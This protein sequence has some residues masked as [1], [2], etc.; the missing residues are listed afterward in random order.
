LG[1]Q[2]AEEAGVVRRDYHCAR[3]VTTYDDY[4]DSCYD[5]YDY[6]SYDYDYF[7]SDY[8]DYDSSDYDYYWWF[9]SFVFCDS[10]GSV[11]FGLCGVCSCDE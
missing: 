8:D 1:C 3:W 11:G 7:W 9:W 5:D 10:F 2:S 4:N 6:S